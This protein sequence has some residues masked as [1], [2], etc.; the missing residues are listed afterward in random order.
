MKKIIMLIS[1]IFPN[2]LKKLI[3]RKFFGWEIGK[4]VKIGFSIVDSKDVKLGDNCK[5]GNFTVI[6]NLKELK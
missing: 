5:I 3:Y 6:K 2:F 4:N 1:I